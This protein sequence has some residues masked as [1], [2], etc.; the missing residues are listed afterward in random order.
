MHVYR[1]SHAALK[2]LVQ[3]DNDSVSHCL[4]FKN[5]LCAS[6]VTGIQALDSSQSSA[7]LLMALM[8]STGLSLILD[9]IHD[10]AC[11]YFEI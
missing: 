6:D 2:H 1:I 9:A 3:L 8:S 11:T 10:E 7:Y 5:V 4:Q